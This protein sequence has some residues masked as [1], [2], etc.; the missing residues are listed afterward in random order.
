MLLLA[1]CDN[2][3]LARH[4]E[5]SSILAWNSLRPGDVYV[6][7]GTNLSLY[8]VLACNLFGTKALHEPMLAQIHSGKL[9]GGGEKSV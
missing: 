9:G 8:H 7:Q 6:H 3:V 2:M 4:R 5:I 1:N